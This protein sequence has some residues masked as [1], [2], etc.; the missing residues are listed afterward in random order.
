LEI[1]ALCDNPRHKEICVPASAKTK[2]RKVRTA[3]ARVRVP[4]AERS[5]ATRGKLLDAT[6][7]CLYELGYHQTS[8]VI[9]TE[10]AG[11][12]RG[13][14]LHHFP[15]KADLM[16]AAANHIREHRRDAHKAHLD[17]FPTEREKFLQLV[18]ILWIEFQ[19]PSG[20]AR[21]EMMLG[22]RSDPELGPRF[23]QLNAELEDLHKERIW[24]RAQR[25]GIKD[26]K[27]IN[28]FVQLYAA[29]IRGLAID[30]LWPR[31]VPDIKAAVALLKEFQLH[32]LDVLL[33]DGSK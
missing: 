24:E 22:S 23:R 25:L 31:S 8:T 15:S 16:M 18:D 32:M 26:R 27:K 17:K 29:A 21:I 5:A 14:M 4:N 33:K 20:I 10:R 7:Q 2:P 3:P 19:T 28:A 12:S 9:V 1:G 11:V 13:S 6:I 30:A